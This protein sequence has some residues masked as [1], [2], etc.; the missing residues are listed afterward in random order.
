MARVY[1]KKR[2]QQYADIS[3]MEKLL[4][5]RECGQMNDAGAERC[6]FCGAALRADIRRPIRIDT[7]QAPA[8]KLRSGH[9]LPDKSGSLAEQESQ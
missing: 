5:C 3:G 9:L 7:R 8:G 4:T 6:R 2:I 1:R